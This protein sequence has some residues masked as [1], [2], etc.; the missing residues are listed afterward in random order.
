VYYV[1]VELSRFQDVRIELLTEGL[2]IPF[3]ERTTPTEVVL[4]FH[5]N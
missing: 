4:H 1:P 5:N 2:H 3:D